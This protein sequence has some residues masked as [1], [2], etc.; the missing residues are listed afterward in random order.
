M[1]RLLARVVGMAIVAIAAWSPSTAWAQPLAIEDF[2]R[3]PQFRGATLS[4]NGA[5]VAGI[6]RE[7]DHEILVVID[8][9]ASSMT[10]IQRV[11]T[12]EGLSFNWV[13]W[14][15]DD[16]LIV[17]TTQQVAIVG[18][19]PIGSSIPVGELGEIPVE[20]L[21]AL[22]RNGGAVVRLF[23]R[24]HTQTARALTTS[25]LVDR[26]AR[27]PAHVL[28]GSYESR[29]YAL[30][31][32]DVATGEMTR[33]E[34]G[35]WETLDWVVDGEG[36]PV[37]RLELFGARGGYRVL[38]RA[39]GERA[40]VRVL[41]V[42]GSERHKAPDFNVLGPGPGA[43][44]VYVSARTAETDRAAVFLYNTATGA[45]GQP[46]YEHPSA[47][48]ELVMIETGTHALIAGCA[49]LQRLECTASDPQVTR[50]LTAI[51]SFLGNQAEVVL[52]GASTDN[53]VWL[54]FAEG[55][56]VPPSYL[57]YDR[58]ARNIVGIG[59]H[60][61]H[62][63]EE[64]LSP[65]EIVAYA[66]RDG[67]ALWGYLTIPRGAAASGAPLVVMPHGGP[68]SRD[69]YG[70]DPL[71]QFLASRGYLVFQP[72]FRGS[73]GFGRAFAELG[74]RQW[75]QRMQDDVTDGVRHLIASGRVDAGR[76]CIL[77]ASYGGYA[78]LAGGAF[79]PDLYR[80]IVSIAGD[81]D[82]PE[83]LRQERRDE[84]RRSSVY[85]YWLASV[86]DPEADRAMLERFSPR[87]HAS[88]FTAPVLLIHGEDD[89]VVPIIQSE[90]M[91]RALRE[92]GRSVRFVRIE[93]EGHH[94]YAWETE[95]T[96]SL[97]REIESFLG[98]HL[99]AN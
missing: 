96:R 92:A 63:A 66:A 91:E 41:E 77:G 60:A 49:R 35:D 48:A 24:Q 74:R 40:W 11:N 90:I 20:R 16:R 99:R 64:Q 31:R 30:Y 18:G 71:A 17:S 3:T 27:D 65:V 89:G 75:G 73:G 51:R 6:R 19:R 57:V 54:L 70:F 1:F 56:T 34:S 72:Q 21:F 80:C 2:I 5:Y 58:T 13:A 62:L 87:D 47:D 28:I 46:V 8:W 37:M 43:G 23:E 82:L 98:E 7:G 97:F 83:L 93:D 55:P 61:P 9:R 36:T 52:A 26:L 12:A 29:G 42:R 33:I 86:G 39:P 79:T 25:Q 10:P 68:E 81:S 78:A 22:D 59:G 85:Q 50:H 69:E 14:K 32:A 76:V 95:K 45:L 44:L 94:F 15:T 67:A 88:N 53:T 84:G 38:R 4:P